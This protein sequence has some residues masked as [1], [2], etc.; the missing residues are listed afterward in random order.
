MSN[1][2]IGEIRLFAGAYAPRGW[3]FCDGRLLSIANYNAFFAL[4]GTIYGGD[5]V[6]NFAVP[7]LRARIPINQGQG[8]G[9]SN[10]AIGEAGGVEQVSLDAST[11]PAH[12]HALNATGATG[13]SPAPGNTVVLATPVEAGVNTSLYVVPGTSGV[14]LAPMAPQSIGMTGGSLPHDN[15]MPTQAINYIIAVEGQFPSRN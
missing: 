13:S 6:T 8:T 4:I 11:M 2:F 14:N 7:D 15:M 5:G 12:Q 1:A 9:L 10:Y 3:V